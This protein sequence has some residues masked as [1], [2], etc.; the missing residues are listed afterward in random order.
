MILSSILSPKLSLQ[1]DII[2]IIIFLITLRPI[3]VIEYNKMLNYFFQNHAKRNFIPQNNFIWGSSNLSNLGKK[4]KRWENAL[5][6]FMHIQEK[7][8]CGLCCRAA[9]ITR[10]FFKTQNPRLINE[11]GFKSRA[12]YDGARTVAKNQPYVFSWNFHIFG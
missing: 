1:I 8:C 11:S 10:N 6:F 9:Y 2:C 7:K 4:E 5:D 12:A 3:L